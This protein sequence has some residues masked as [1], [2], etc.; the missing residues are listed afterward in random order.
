MNDKDYPI[1][2]KTMYFQLKVKD[3]ERAKKFYEDIFG[4]E[5][6][7]YQSP[8]V[9]WCEFYLPGGS[10]RLGLNVVAEGEEIAPSSGILTIS[11]ENI[12]STKTY[13]EN[14]GIE[15]TEIIDIPN[16]VSYFNMKDSEGNAIQIVADPRVNE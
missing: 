9:G 8:D 3:I 5:V 13:L 2:Y 11:V 15:T 12:E 4:F 6:S 10:P 1:K 14:K 16:L 7:W